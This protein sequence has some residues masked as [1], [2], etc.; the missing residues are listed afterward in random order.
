M[1]KFWFE[2]KIFHLNAVKND[3]YPRLNQRGVTT[4]PSHSLA[5]LSTPHKTKNKKNPVVFFK[6]HS[7]I[8]K[9]YT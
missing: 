2:F 8:E 6:P 5:Y 1:Q 9:K 7:W 4:L 3:A